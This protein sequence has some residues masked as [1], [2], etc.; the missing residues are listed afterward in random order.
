MIVPLL[1]FPIRGAVWYQGE[2]NSG[3]AAEA[4][5]YACQMQAMIADWRQHWANS[6]GFVFNLAQL[7]AWKTGPSVAVLRYSQLAST[8]MPG[9]GMSVGVDLADP[10]SP[11]GDVHIRLGRV[12]GGGGSKG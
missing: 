9:V 1:R 2:A 4:N 11:C 10:H 8:T 6:S 7:A 12:G 3:S 5:R